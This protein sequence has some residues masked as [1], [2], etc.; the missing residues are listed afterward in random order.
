M[1]SLVLPALF[2]IFVT[3]TLATT[4]C[5]HSTPWI[6]RVPSLVEQQGA[7]ARVRVVEVWSKNDRLGLEV[8]VANA[9]MEPIEV[10][11]D[12]IILVFPD[13]R[14]LQRRRSPGK[15]VT[16]IAPGRGETLK[17]DFEDASVDWSQ[18]PA[19]FVDLTLAV[20]VHGTGAPVPMP[21]V[22]VQP[23]R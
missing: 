13:G 1:R 8:H 23:G 15:T 17:I 12:A 11:R 2:T 6:S 10:D 4:G 16:S 21:K 3:T 14:R 20:T 19:L 5:G 22:W 18:S 7:P 9:T